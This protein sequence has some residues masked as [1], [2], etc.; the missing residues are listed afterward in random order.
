MKLII[1]INEKSYLQSYLSILSIGI[2]DCIEKDIISYD[3]AMNLL[4]FPSMIEKLE[5]LLP[6]LGEAI[7]LGTELEDVSEIVPD[8]LH[9]SI[10]QIRLLNETSIEFSNDS[11]QHVFYK[12][13]I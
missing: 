8:K 7:H 13:N 3:D 6:N 12:F 5:R 2:L 4:Y 10:E 11:K 9:D 1:E